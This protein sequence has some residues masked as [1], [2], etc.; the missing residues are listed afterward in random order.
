M[1]RE[2]SMLRGAQRILYCSIILE[3]SLS[4]SFLSLSA[5]ARTH[6]CDDAVLSSIFLSLVYIMIID[7]RVSLISSVWMA[8]RIWLSRLLYWRAVS[9]S[10]QQRDQERE[11]IAVYFL[12]GSFLAEHHQSAVWCTTEHR[13]GFYPQWERA[14]TNRLAAV[15]LESDKSLGVHVFKQAF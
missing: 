12:R 15:P 14:K 3:Y 13:R 5:V 9:W 4:V 1:F 11:R 10:L 8:M 7:P 2:K 6:N